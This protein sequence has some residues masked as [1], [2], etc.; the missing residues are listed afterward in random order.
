MG[1][2]VSDTASSAFVMPVPGPAV[3]QAIG[4]DLARRALLVTPAVVLAAGLL[5]ASAGALG[6]LLAL[7][8]VA[9]SFLSSA[10]AVTWAARIS[11]ATVAAVA[12]GGY[13]V[14]LGVISLIGVGVRQLSFV[15]FPTFGVVLVVGY[16]GVLVW[17][18]RSVS[19][20][21]AA[22]GLRPAG[23]KE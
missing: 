15:D 21:F 19:L 17:E 8:V 2:A 10:A 7:L 11:M 3:E 23:E 14:R 4:R 5:R 18:L 9:G 6:A 1:E 16:L 20:T 22:P 13:V 12:L